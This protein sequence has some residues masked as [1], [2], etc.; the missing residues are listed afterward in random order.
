V[1]E[2]DDVLAMGPG[3]D[4]DDWDDYVAG[5]DARPLVEL[6]PLVAELRLPNAMV[7]LRGDV[8]EGVVE[9]VADLADPR[10]EL[11]RHAGVVTLS[12]EHLDASTSIVD[13]ER[14]EVG[15]GAGVTSLTASLSAALL[16]A[17]VRTD[18]LRLHLDAANVELDDRL[19]APFGLVLVDPDATSRHHL[20]AAML[21]D[22]AR[23]L[24][25]DRTLVLPGSRAN[26]ALPTPLWSTDGWTRGSA[27]SSLVTA[28]RS[29]AVVFVRRDPGAAAGMQRLATA[30]GCARLVSGTGALERFGSAALDAV[31]A[32]CAEATFWELVHDDLSA[33]ADLLTTVSP[34]TTRELVTSCRLDRPQDGVV[35][36]PTDEEGRARSDAVRRGR[37]ALRTARFDRAA[38]CVDGDV[39]SVAVIDDEQADQLEQQLPRP[40]AGPAEARLGLPNSPRDGLDATHWSTGSDGVALQRLRVESALERLV[41]LLEGAGSV[42]VVLGDVVQAHDGLLPM[43]ATAVDRV[44]LLV[45]HAEVEGLAEVLEAH[46][47]E[48]SPQRVGAGAAGSSVAW[49]DPVRHAVAAPATEPAPASDD[50]RGVLVVLHWQLA[51]GPFGELVDHDELL[52]RS[53]PCQISGRWYRALHPEDRFVLA[54]VRAGMAQRPSL[55]Q[56]RSVVLTAPRDELMMAAALEASERWGATRVVLSAIRAADVALPGIAPWLVA[57]ARPGATGAGP[58]QDAAPEPRR[59]RLIRRR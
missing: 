52:D 25:A 9:A 30:E 24:S 5:E 18:P 7:H 16:D 50:E 40:P 47:Y 21:R 36:G 49:T 59:R 19:G 4:W 33:A 38:V 29:R 58:D 23:Y 43:D 41:D 45:E 26:V 39:G 37:A 13:L 48:L 32:L 11:H 54:C 12:F 14:G 15:G 2:F 53:V 17:A 34:A 57:R 35:G 44:D 42:P 1:G 56:L 3:D 22:G 20:V 6:A 55:E 10:L 28:T 31:A 8:P 46:G 51:V 27:G